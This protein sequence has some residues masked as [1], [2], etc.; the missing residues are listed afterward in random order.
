MR[1]TVPRG[2]E[3][4]RHVGEFPAPIPHADDLEALADAVREAGRVE[5]PVAP[6]IDAADRPPRAPA[7]RPARLADRALAT[8]LPDGSVRRRQGLRRARHRARPA[9]RAVARALGA[10]FVDVTGADRIVTAHDMRETGPGLAR[11]FAEGALHRGASVVEA[12][13]ASTDMLY[14]ASGHAEPARRDVHRQPQPGPLQRHQVLPSRRAGDR[15]RHRPRR[16]PRRGRGATSTDG[17]PPAATP[18]PVEQADLLADYAR[19]LR[20]LVDLTGIRP[21]KVVVDAGNGMAGLHGAGR[22]R[23]CG[24]ARAAARD[25]PAVLR[26]GRLVPQPRG[27]SAR[28]GQ[29]RRPAGARRRPKA[30]TS[31]SPSTATPT[32]ASS[33][34]RRRGR[35]AERDHLPGRGARAA[36]RARRR[37]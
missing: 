17:L 1:L 15:P 34:T 29:P 18:G 33:S 19:Y 25:R 30:P 12:G 6:D 22:A 23:R 16:D 32:A 4:L 11:A 5:H 7:R 28:A 2:W 36:T 26:A 8:T 9:R 20:G 21:L 31:G 24:A 37:R 10:A 3:V 13:L 14:F 27:Q 35:L